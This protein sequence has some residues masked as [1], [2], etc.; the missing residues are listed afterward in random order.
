MDTSARLP[1]ARGPHGYQSACT[2]APLCCVATVALELASTT[3]PGSAQ[4]SSLLEGSRPSRSDSSCPRSGAP[5]A[6]VRGLPAAEG[7]R[8]P[9]GL[10]V[11]S[12]AGGILGAS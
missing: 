9:S 6:Q 7:R 8:G 2:T 3:A 12:R 11:G 10:G 5:W 4:F 1:S